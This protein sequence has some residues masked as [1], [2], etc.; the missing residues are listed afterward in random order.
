MTSK[1]ASRMALA[2]TLA[3]RSCPSSPAFATKTRIFRAM[4]SSSRLEDRRLA[5]DAESPAE[6]VADLPQRGLGANGVEH[7]GDEILVAHAGVAERLHGR[8][9]LRRVA[10]RA[11]LLH[12]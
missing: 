3:P 5:V 2:T 8:R 12:A 7:E 11:D 4:N 10:R 6:R 1:P 9:V